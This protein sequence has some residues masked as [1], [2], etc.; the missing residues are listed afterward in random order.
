MVL[1]QVETEC[2]KTSYFSS[3]Q[4]LQ[5]AVLSSDCSKLKVA[6]AQQTYENLQILD[7]FRN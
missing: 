1:S 2:R 7:V 3:C 5:Y 6:A 4:E